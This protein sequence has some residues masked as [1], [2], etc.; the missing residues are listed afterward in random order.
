MLKE[1]QRIGEFE[2]IRLLGKGGMGEVYEAQQSNPARR[3]ALKVLAP[4]LAEDSDAL[5][6]FMR[7]A[8]VPAQ[9]DHPAVVRIYSTGKCDGVAYYAMQL[10]RGISLAS[11]ILRGRPATATASYETPN[12]RATPLSTP[13][14]GGLT[15]DSPDDESRVPPIIKEYLADRFRTTAKLGIQAARALAWTHK[16][17]YLHRDIKPSNL[18]V[19][20]HDQLYL[21]DFG[22]ARA[23]DSGLNTR[24]GALIGTPYYM[25]PE[26]A[27][28]K[29]LDPRSDIYSLG[30][31]LY[32]LISGGRG[33]YRVAPDDSE[34]VLREV[35][36]GVLVPLR[37]LAPEVPRMLEAIIEKA[38]HAK[39]ERRYSS[40]EML[41]ADLERYLKAPAAVAAKGAP[42]AQVGMRS[43]LIGA[44]ALMLAGIAIPVGVYVAHRLRE[45][46][47]PPINAPEQK[48][49]AG[50]AKKADDTADKKK[51]DLKPAVF[52]RDRPL[53]VKVNLLRA[54]FQ[55]VMS[56]QYLADGKFHAIPG[57]LVFR[58]PQGDNRPALLALDDPGEQNF[59]FSVE[60]KAWDQSKPLSNDL[61]IF[62]GWQ[63]NL[64]DPQERRRFFALHLDRRQ[65]L[66]DIHGR[67]NI[68]SWL[69]EEAKGARGGWN[70]QNVRPLHQ[71]RGFP[72]LP[73]PGPNGWYR[74][75]ARVVGKDISVGVDNEAS[76]DFDIDWMT[77]N[78]RWLKSFTLDT[79]GALGI[80]VRNGQGSFRNITITALPRGK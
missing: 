77:R 9:L 7:E 52:E 33:P 40:A 2:I 44:A 1:A 5:E 12:D 24:Y 70:E 45:E 11:L 47:Q 17:G 35:R 31:S 51:P 73:P 34:A 79:R 64:P 62:F 23:F 28:G 48:P 65:A 37:A 4:W 59:E 53:R 19:D 22:L 68:G 30:V 56:K 78:D 76:T 75:W 50:D 6:R 15:V 32:Q 72:A 13:V 49:I 57:E 58:S 63:D 71:G 39:P 27:D 25:S 21:L 80:W 36:S 67:L 66:K 29:P 74:V 26:Q 46:P 3:V 16:R 61:G 55:P 41:A 38:T 60:M 18:M 20:F 43:V 8:E 69:F 14:R 54:D 42:R 10:V